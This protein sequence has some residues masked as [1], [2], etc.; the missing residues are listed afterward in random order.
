M[1]L[2]IRL[3]QLRLGLFVLGVPPYEVGKN[4]E[5]G[6]KRSYREDEDHR[7]G[8]RRKEV[9]EDDG[10]AEPQA[11]APRTV[12]ER[13]ERAAQTLGLRTYE[14]IAN[15]LCYRVVREKPSKPPHC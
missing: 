15:E 12:K 7:P 14:P 1:R 5:K 3:Q 10:R 6:T 11:R 4:L 8:V 9:E 2:S 13:M